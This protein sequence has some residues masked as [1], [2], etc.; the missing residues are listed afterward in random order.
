MLTSLFFGETKIYTDFDQN[1]NDFY[2][3]TC[4]ESAIKLSKS[5][6]ITLC[7]L[8][9]LQQLYCIYDIC[10]FSDILDAIQP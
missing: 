8:N 3:C 4:D 5:T 2:I 10:D 7:L 1:H 6:I 9:V